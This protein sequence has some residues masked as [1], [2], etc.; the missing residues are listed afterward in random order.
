MC[1][2]RSPDNRS[3]TERRCEP[4]RK[5]TRAASLK[6][7]NGWESEGLPQAA[8][9]SQLMVK[10]IGVEVAAAVPPPYGPPGIAGLVTVTGTVP[11]FMIA[12]AAI[13]V[14]SLVELT[15]VVAWAAPL[16]FM[17]ALEAKFVPSTSKVKAGPPLFALGG[18]RPVITGFVPCLIG[19]V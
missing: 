9:R 4:H 6:D 13:M 19:V 1:W 16:K 18:T 11:E 7:D 17:L 12:V 5:C 10:F 15:L 3:N 14:V 8:L 2:P